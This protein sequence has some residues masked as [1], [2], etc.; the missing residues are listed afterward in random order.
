MVHNR[1]RYIDSTHVTGR[2]NPGAHTNAPGFFT[3]RGRQTVNTS[4]NRRP[5]AVHAALFLALLILASTLICGPADAKGPVSPRD[6]PSSSETR[7][8]DGSSSSPPPKRNDSSPS[9][10]TQPKSDDRSSSG[11]SIS[12]NSGRSETRDEPTTGRD[13]STGRT[14]GG[15]PTLGGQI[16]KRDEKRDPEYEYRKHYRDPFYYPYDRHFW[17]YYPYY[18]RGSVIVVDPTWPSPRAKYNREYTYRNPLPG[19]IEEALCDVEATWWE[20]QPEYLMWHI[21]AN[22]SVDVYYKGEY[23]H[24]V[25]PRELYKLTVESLDQIRTTEF[26]FTSLDRD[27]IEARAVARHEFD[28]PDGKHRTAKLVYYF[29]KDRDRWIITQIDF[30]QTS[31]GSP[32]CFIATA[33]Y[34]TDMED[35]VLVLREFR[36]KYL[37]TN[38]TGKALVEM[39]YTLSPPI[40]D[41]IRE[42][43]SAKAAVRMLLDPIVQ[44]C[45]VLVGN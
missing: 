38:P 44:A 28:G 13:S 24:S 8:S 11:A 27:G 19:S 35:D 7:D 14:D 37:L 42:N 41:G 1:G 2:I 34:G 15:T 21:D 33:A 29:V 45:R 31:Y 5:I 12:G 9:A 3:M 6:K 39:Y 26:R 20:R 17:T 4:R 22:R 30:S 40:A 32:K 18:D 23:S 10:P 43:E 25:T 36:D 16:Q